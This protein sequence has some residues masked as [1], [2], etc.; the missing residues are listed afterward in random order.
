MADKLKDERDEIAAEADEAFGAEDLGTALMNELSE[1]SD[2]E[3]AIEPGTEADDAELGDGLSGD[4]DEVV[5]DGAP[6]AEGEEKPAAA[7]GV[8]R[9]DGRDTKGKFASKV[10]QDAADRAT[11]DAKAAGKSEADQRAAATAAAAAVKPAAAADDAAKAPAWEPL[12]IKSNRALFPIEEA[13]VTKQGGHVLIA[14]PEKD[15]NKFQH[16]IGRGIAAEQQVR[17]MGQMRR[18]LEFERTAPKPRS[19]AEVEAAIVLDAITPHLG[20]LHV[21]DEATGEYVPFLDAKTHENL[22]LKVEIAQSKEKADFAKAETERRSAATSGEE[23]TKTQIETLTDQAFELVENHPDLKGMTPDQIRTALEDLAM[24]V[25]DKI[26]FRE[27]GETFANTEYLFKL[28]KREMLS[29]G[30]AAPAP[31]GQPA[32]PKKTTDAE[33]FNSGQDTAAKPATTSLKA[34]RP[35]TAPVRRPTRETVPASQQRDERQEAEDA[36]RRARRKMMS[37]STLDWDDDDEA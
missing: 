13:K 11:A 8:D 19:D 25:R 33:R 4:D 17:E 9:G 14:V 37:S 5:E 34:K 10:E 20:K 12:Q 27:N 15:Y 26:V 31:A 16:R 3:L 7:E 28:L 18:E 36:Q 1:E 32:A 2:S 6:P 24:P 22:K 29:S 30:R 23:W 21:L 35:P